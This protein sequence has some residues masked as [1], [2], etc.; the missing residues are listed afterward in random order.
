MMDS[1][2]NFESKENVKPYNNV[3]EM[4]NYKQSNKCGYLQHND[5]R[6]KAPIKMTI[7]FKDGNNM[8]SC[9]IH[10]KI[11][12]NKIKDDEKVDVIIHDGKHTKEYKDYD[13]LDALIL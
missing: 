11:I 8:T 6:C 3:K 1:L 13:K 4:I 2:N 7:I 12:I 5:K 9:L 10:K